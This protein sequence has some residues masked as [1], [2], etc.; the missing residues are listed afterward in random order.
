MNIILKENEWAEKM[1]QD[2]SLGKKPYQTLYRV[3]RYYLDSGYSKTEVRKRLDI[4]LI[5]CDPSASL[6]TWSETLDNALKR[7]LKYGAIDIQSIIITKPEMDRI[8]SIGGRQLRRLAFTLLCLAKYWYA[9]SPVTD[10]WVKNRDNEIMAM[11]NINTSIKRQCAMFGALKELGVLRFSKRID[12]T[13]VRVCF[14][15]EGETAL[16]IT[17]FRNLGYQY[18]KYV[19]EPYFECVNCGIT[20]KYNNPQKGRKQKYCKACAEEIDLQH[21]INSVLRKRNSAKKVHSVEFSDI[22]KSTVTQ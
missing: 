19:G 4:F 11:A 12:N 10:Y 18:L 17:D 1:I 3:A 22:H 2:R 8:D 5:Q 7:A 6:T 9:V 13:N 15:E 14:A 20:V 16:E 21:R